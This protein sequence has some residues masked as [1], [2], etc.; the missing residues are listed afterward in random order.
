M[1]SC[2][3]MRS[4]L[5]TETSHERRPALSSLVKRIDGVPMEEAIRKGNETN[6]AISSNKTISLAAVGNRL[7]PGLRESLPCWSGTMAAYDKPDK[8]LGDEIEFTDPKSGIS[9]MFRVPKE[10]VGKSNVALVALHPDFTL[11]P[12][13]M[14]RIV[15]AKSVHAIEGFPT[16]SGNWHLGDPIHDVPCG[17]ACPSSAK[18]ARL[19]WRIE[20]RVGLVARG[21]EPWGRGKRTIGLADLPSE[22]FGVLVEGGSGEEELWV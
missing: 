4:S 19:L 1:E 15:I 3:S 17:E 13:G 11:E 16:T 9:Y 8:P 22:R 21:C 12:D 18:D 6:L 2:D 7:S 14:R 10:H 5:S 20:K